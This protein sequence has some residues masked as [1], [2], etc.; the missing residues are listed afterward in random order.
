M[1]A[2]ARN[3]LWWPGLDTEIEMRVEDGAIRQLHSKQP[4]A[5]PLHPWEWPGQTWHWA[6]I[7]C[8]SPF[9]GRMILIIVDVHNTYIDVR[10]VSAAT[11]S[12]TITKLR[13]TFA[14]VCLPNIIGRTMEGV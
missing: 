5:A 13:Q 9:E 1:K 10:V 7:D 8:A 4:P 11:T 6:H 14:G 3:Y 2:V 12:A